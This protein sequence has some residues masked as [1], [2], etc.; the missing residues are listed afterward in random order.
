NDGYTLETTVTEGVG[1]DR[2]RV[3]AT[4]GE[5]PAFPP[6]TK[7]GRFS[8]FTGP[9]GEHLASIVRGVVIKKSLPDKQH[10]LVAEAELRFR[11]SKYRRGRHAMFPRAVVLATVSAA[12]PAPATPAE[13][14]QKA[15]ELYAA[16]KFGEAEPLFQAA[17]RAEDRFVK[18]N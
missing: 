6:G 17:L 5:P 11:V 7:V 1:V 14:F 3:I 13:A 4:I 8:V 12:D 10:T 15:E 2:L 18:R 16:D 9:D